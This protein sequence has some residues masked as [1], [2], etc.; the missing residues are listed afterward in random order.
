MPADEP[1]RR[2]LEA[3]PPFL[4]WTAL[5]VLVAVLLALELAAFALI[6]VAYR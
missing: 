2:E 5:Y 6:T 1:A 3:R 4:S